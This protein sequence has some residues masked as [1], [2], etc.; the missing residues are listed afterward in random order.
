MSTAG[1]IRR[2][3]RGDD[4]ASSESPSPLRSF[5]R[6]AA[7]FWG[8]EDWAPWIL[9]GILLLIVLLNL[10]ASY[11][12]NVWNRGIFDALQT[13]DSGT[14]LQLSLLYL[15]LL[16]GSGPAD[17]D[18]GMGAHDDAAALARLAQYRS[19]RSLASQRPLL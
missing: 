14:V 8:R 17:G 7:G 5:W 11:G 19:S 16:A 3:E 10:A 2:S 1:E 9:S 15:P 4:A 12:M 18:A 6:S 13:R